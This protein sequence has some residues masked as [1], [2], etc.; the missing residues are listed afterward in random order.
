MHCV[1]W[2]SPLLCASVLLAAPFG[3]E[4]GSKCWVQSDAIP[5]KI[6]FLVG[7]NAYD[8]R[9]FA[10][11]QY[12]ERDVEELAKVLRDQGYSVTLLLGSGRG[13]DHAILANVRAG[14]KRALTGVTKRDLVLVGL[15]GHGLTL[16]VPQDSGK[17]RDEAFFCPCD[18]IKN[19]PKSMLGM[20]ELFAAIDERGGGQNLILIDACRDDPTRGGDR[21]MDG[22]RVEALPKGVAV[23][24]SCSAGQ[25]AHESEK[26]GGG[27]GIFFHFVLEGLRGKARTN[28]RGEIT[29]SSLSDYVTEHVETD[30]PNLYENARGKQIPNEVKNLGRSPALVTL[31]KPRDENSPA[32]EAAKGTPRESPTSNPAKDRQASLP[33]LNRGNRDVYFDDDKALWVLYTQGER[34][35]AQVYD[36]KTG[37]K[38][39]APMQHQWA[40]NSAVFS[41]DGKS[42]LTANND[43]TARVWS[44]A[45]GQPITPP[46]RH[47]P[48]DGGKAF[49]NG[50]LFSPDGRLVATWGYDRMVRFW[51]AKTGQAVGKPIQ[52]QFGF[53][54]A[55]F[56]PDGE[57]LLT[58]TGLFYR[59]P[60]V[61]QVWNV[62]SGNSAGW[63]I[64]DGEEVRAWFSPDGS[65]IGTVN[66]E[67]VA[68]V[69]DAETGSAVGTPMKASHQLN[70]VEFSPD[71]SRILTVSS[72]EF[73]LW[74]ASTGAPLLPPTEEKGLRRVVFC[75]DGQRIAAEGSDA[76][77]LWNAR[78]GHKLDDTIPAPGNMTALFSPDGQR[79]LLIDPGGTGTERRAN[80][81]EIWD[82]A[83]IKLI[84]RVNV[85]GGKLPETD[86]AGK[87]QGAA[88]VIWSLWKV[89]LDWNGKGQGVRVTEI[90]EGGPAA[91]AG[92][93]A[94]DRIVEVNGKGVAD[95]DSFCRGM[96]EKHDVPNRV[97]LVRNDKRIAV[98]VEDRAR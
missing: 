43:G 58:V 61:V 66:R 34:A 35:F 62:S 32:V 51:D 10:D 28:D 55:A 89:K 91:R 33:K 30:L 14:L 52:H 29:W 57:R 59:E 17:T 98:D 44:A 26:A 64:R 82:L 11:L 77:S 41:P 87:P 90:A 71:G 53:A 75:I 23:L 9:A 67:N 42:V 3:P 15:A 49:V 73:R 12:A 40:L 83:S 69:W 19:D 72:D 1:R 68:R 22:S 46:L 78:T 84:S 50:G 86:S 70:Y 60:R 96:E 63:T 21:G 80:V 76:I 94:G 95:L 25:K 37:K 27:H 93:R 38:V 47:L 48:G 5:K 18:A 7:V 16:G 13:L 92:I 56:S 39:G 81:A 88:G 54:Q 85:E 2:L 6:A 36:V 31:E 20:G 4:A 79:A 74:N 45:T 65:R 8:T 97:V 24:F